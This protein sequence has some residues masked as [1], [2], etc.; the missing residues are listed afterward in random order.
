MMSI[1]SKSPVED[2]IALPPTRRVTIKDEKKDKE[3]LY[4]ES[5]QKLVKSLVNDIIDIKKNVYHG[6]HMLKEIFH[7]LV[8]RF[9]MSMMKNKENKKKM[10]RMMRILILLM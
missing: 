2:R 7:L 3:D 8:I 9:M 1:A 10:N 5:L 4:I 6:D